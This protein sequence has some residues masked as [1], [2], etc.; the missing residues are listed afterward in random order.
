MLNYYSLLNV[1]ISSSVE[2]IRKAYIDLIKR[3]HPDTFTGDTTLAEL[4]TRQ[5][6]EAYETLSKPELRYMYDKSLKSQG[7]ERKTRS[8][9]KSQVKPSSNN[10]HRRTKFVNPGYPGTEEE[11]KKELRR[12]EMEL[13]NRWMTELSKYISEHRW[14]ENVF[15]SLSE[16]IKLKAMGGTLPFKEAFKIYCLMQK[17]KT[18]MGF[19]T[20]YFNEKTIEKLLAE[21]NTE[22]EIQV[23]LEL[24]SRE[25][26]ILQIYIRINSGIFSNMYLSR[27][28]TETISKFG[29]FHEFLNKR[30][31]EFFVAV[32]KFSLSSQDWKLAKELCRMGIK[33][34]WK[35]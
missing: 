30:P 13:T 22:E 33:D 8:I 35:I 34:A 28:E 17:R 26:I 32:N 16:D 3:W 12:K 25:E 2:D 19:K 5:L 15:E 29:K 7:H 31:D 27:E 4:M 21:S 10:S 24:I 23:S 20:A 1:S 14:A 18:S 9:H 11:Y 6:N